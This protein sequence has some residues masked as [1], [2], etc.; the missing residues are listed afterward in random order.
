YWRIQTKKARGILDA[1]SLYRGS[2]L[3]AL[4][5]DEK[6][7]LTGNQNDIARYGRQE[8]AARLTGTENPVAYVSLSVREMELDAY[9]NSLYSKHT[10]IP[11][12]FPTPLADLAYLPRILPE[13]TA[14][15]E[16][17][18][19]DSGLGHRIVLLVATVE[20]GKLNL[21]SYDLNDKGGKPISAQTFGELALGYRT[22][23]TIPKA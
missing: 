20:K 7:A 3:S 23:C 22:A 2:L 10:D 5:P 14:L 17:A 4:S 16:Y 9:V 1:S 15:L 12:S 18:A 11:P 6:Q 19:L 8:L 13:D 21:K